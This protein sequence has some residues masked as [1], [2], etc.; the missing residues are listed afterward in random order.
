MFFTG[1][2]RAKEGRRSNRPDWRKGKTGA[3]SS[4]RRCKDPSHTGKKEEDEGKTPKKRG[5]NELTDAENA[6][7]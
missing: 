7:K 4:V 1:R 6:D 2:G 3:Q 5:K